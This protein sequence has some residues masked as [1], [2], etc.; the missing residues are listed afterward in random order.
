MLSP[1]QARELWCP[2][3]RVAQVGAAETTATYN[4]VLTKTHV[5]VKLA[6]ASPEG[7][8]LGEEPKPIAA[9]MLKVDL[10]LSRA[11]RCVANECVM[12]RWVAGTNV[13][14]RRFVDYL[15]ETVP[16]RPND[17]GPEWV[18]VPRNEENGEPA[19]WTEPEEMQKSRRRGYCG[20]AGIPA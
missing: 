4:R 1:E 16:K 14:K 20:L 9:T 2:M 8:E 5:P 15:G 11:A 19:F 18:F 7:F 3:A 12:W 6:D 13:R 10:Q 17:V